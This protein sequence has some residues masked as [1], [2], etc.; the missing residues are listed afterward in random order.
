MQTTQKPL[1]N[2]CS[3]TGFFKRL[4]M[5]VLDYSQRKEGFQRPRNKEDIILVALGPRNTDN[6]FSELFILH[7]HSSSLH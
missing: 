5:N 7:I 2:N 6:A 3:I 4:I 1:F